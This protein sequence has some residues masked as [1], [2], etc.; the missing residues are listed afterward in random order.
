[1]YS[2]GTQRTLN[3]KTND[4]SITWLVAL[5]P[6]KKWWLCNLFRWV[7]H[8]KVKVIR[9]TWMRVTIGQDSREKCTCF[10]LGDSGFP[11]KSISLILT[12]ILNLTSPSKLHLQPK[13]KP[14]PTTQQTGQLLHRLVAMTLDWM[15]LS[16]PHYATCAAHFIVFLFFCLAVGQQKL[17]VTLKSITVKSLR[18]SYL[19]WQTRNIIQ[20]KVE[21]FTG[22]VLFTL[23][24]LNCQLYQLSRH[25]QFITSAVCAVWATG[26]VQRTL[27]CF[28]FIC[29]MK[30]IY[31]IN[32]YLYRLSL[33]HGVSFSQTTSLQ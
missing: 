16:C 8:S 23:N 13:P 25:L 12:P 28:Y 1:M 19:F 32:L 33:R 2:L 18:H 9:W 10:L 14:K 20:H 11:L 26:T 31:L 17:R 22:N 7:A 6:I 15:L 27:M 5:W 21:T 4:S 29:F 30:E 24:I 3:H